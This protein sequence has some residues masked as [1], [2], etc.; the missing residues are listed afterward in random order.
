MKKILCFILIAVLSLGVLTSCDQIGGAWDS[1]SGT[2]G[3]LIDGILGNDQQPAGPTLEDAANFLND[4]YKDKNE[5]TRA[6]FDVVGKVIVDGVSFPV[7]WTSDNEAVTVRPS[8]KAGY[9]TVDLPD[10][11]SAKLSYVLTATITDAEGNTTTKS[12]TFTMPAIDNSGITSTPVEG[13]AYKL[14]LLQGGENRRYYALNTTQNNENKFINTTL[15]PKDGVDFFVEAVDGGYKI[16]TEVNGVK[17]YMYAKVTRSEDPNTGAV[18]YSKFIGFNT[19]EGSVFT[20]NQNKGGVWTV[21]VDN[22]VYGVGT[23][24]SYTTISLSEESR[25]TPDSVGSSQF[26]MKFMTSEYANTL[27]EDKLPESPSDAK[28]ILDQ[29]YAL[30]DGESAAGDFTLTGKIIA[31][32]GYN[33]PTIVVE[34]YENMPV[35]C[36]R[37]SVENKIG[38]V[39]T[40]NATQMKNYGGTYEFMS[41]TLVDGGN[42]GEGGNTPSEPSNLGIVDSPE[43]GKAYKFGLVHGGHGNI[44]VYFNGQNYNNYA[45]Y[46]AYTENTAEAVDVYLEAVEGVENAYRLFFYNGEAKTYIV[47]FPRDGDTTKGTLKLDTATPAEYFTFNTEYNT[48]VYTSTTGEQFYLGSSGT[49]TSISCSAISY[50]SSAT[51]Y[52]A[53]LYAEGATGGEAPHTHEF[54]N[55]KCACGE[56]DPDYVAPDMPTDGNY[57]IPQVLAAAEGTEVKVTGTVESFYYAWDDSYGNC[58]VYIVDEAGNKLLCFRLKT[59]VEIGD[60]I[61]VTGTVA[62]YNG[63]NQLAQG[64]TAVING[65][66]SGSDTP[67]EPGPDTPVVPEDGIYTIPEAL[68]AEVGT[69]VI[70]SGQVI[71]VN[72]VWNTQFNNMSVT[73]ADAEGN[74][75]YVFRMGTQV[76][77][78]D[79]ITVTGTV[80]EYNGA[81]QIAQGS[82]AVVTGHEDLVVDATCK[83]L[84]FADVANRTSFSTDKQVWAANGITLTNNK[85]E[86]TQNVADY[87]APARFYAKTEVIVECAGMT[88]ITF[89]LNSG[90]PA[91]GLTDS[92]ANVAGITIETSGNDITIIFD[93]AV[94]SF[95]FSLVAQIRVDSIDV[96]AA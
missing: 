49:Y 56:V 80:G 53:H 93:S 71:E 23:Y 67:V 5:I 45:W 50:I 47:A 46:L 54:V 16:Y 27:G 73:I 36:Y 44:S 91:S 95:S 38:D 20:Y 70:V 37:L 4:I 18:K 64:C 87:S 31:L 8:T 55:G 17:T 63:T 26:V 96:Y 39:I 83:T 79:F 24:G 81:K 69:N 59:K 88:K 75:L 2:V 34:G 74:E 13:V 43:V 1:I 68:A 28:G 77:A 76:I 12:Y 25:F 3:G 62:V 90:K 65:G 78:G 52:V 11:N 60:N 82:T 6:D 35:Y 66:N 48:L 22:L 92:L 19:E 30:A 32:D 10:I 41:C 57:T 9:F 85:A 51:S 42:S 14:F 33:N 94:D 7:T 72:Q 15:N 61:T 58:S 89:N 21:T 84:S 40:V 86:S 29:L